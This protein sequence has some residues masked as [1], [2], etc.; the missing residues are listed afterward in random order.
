MSPEYSD[1]YEPQ[2]VR[3]SSSQLPTVHGDFDVVV[4]RDRQGLEHSALIKG[5]LQDDIPL[6]RLHSECLTGDAFG[7]L[8]CDCGEQLNKSLQMINAHGAGMV[9]YL[10]QEGRGIGLGNKIKAYELQD[11]GMDTV[12]ANLK[13]GF[14]ADARTYD[15]AADILRQLDVHTLKLISN[16]PA[17]CEALKALGITITEQL[18][19]FTEQNSHNKGYLHTKAE[20]MGHNLQPLEENSVKP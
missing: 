1:E 18:P 19:L 5:D 20:K 7:S 16:N 8:R 17:K 12:D 15:V 2:T 4:Y 3:V 9:I 13:L 14:P 6:V 10:R 11:Q